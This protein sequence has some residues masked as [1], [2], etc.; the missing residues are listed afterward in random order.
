MLGPII[1]QQA[2]DTYILPGNFQGLSV[3]LGGYVLLVIAGFAAH[4]W[5]LIQLETAGLQIIGT[6]K[7]AAFRHLVNLDLPFFDQHT[8][9]KLVSRIENDANAM[10]I[11][12]SSVMS[13]VVSNLLV[14]IG[15]FGIMAWQYDLK[16]AVYVV[17]ICPLIL[18]AGVLFQRL[19]R[20]LLIRIREKVAEVN[21]LLTEVIQGIGTIQM[22]EQQ[23]RF[24]QRIKESSVAKNRLESWMTIG[25]NS[26]FNVLFFVQNLALALVL[27]FGGNL[28]MD[29]GLSVGSLVLFMV[30]IRTFFG[31]IMFLS[32]Q[33]NE[34]QKAVAGGHRIFDLL[35]Q[36]AQVQNPTA[37]VTAPTGLW[38]IEFKNVYFR[39]PGA[40]G[41]T[42]ENVSFHCKAGE[43]WALVGSTGSGKT[44]IISLL[45]RFYDPQRGQILVN[46]IDIQ[47]LLLKD[48]RA[49]V[50]LVLQDVIFFPGTL[51]QNLVLD[52]Q[53]LE[54]TQV[55]STLSTIG[56]DQLIERL[57]T[58][59]DTRLEEGAHNLSE[60]EQQLLSFGR[61]LLRDPQLLIL[62]EATSH[63]DPETEGKIQSAMHSVLR[64]R[65][66]LIIAHR[67]STIE[68]T[69]QILV[70]DQGK[71]IETGSHRELIARE[72]HYARLHEL[73][74]QHV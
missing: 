54:R 65:T 43:H 40:E 67:L 63:V 25:F 20:P 50:G 53:Q 31:P 73:Q 8:T 45:L 60:G 59:Y 7:K 49:G 6:L 16:L 14:M 2:I 19:M 29:G 5:Q 33:F 10:K 35:Q 17:G 3:L 9:G 11:L 1:L 55:K 21:G 27:W 69:D 41:W 58:G 39:Y 4:Y 23:D 36:R 30:F 64:G 12:F 26:F 13:N 42:L 22:F 37:P 56:L 32:S 61:A 18:A 52:N 28:V 71:V 66:A 44:T 38:D 51:W 34:F 46:G 68:A 47:T 48:L 57:P 15:M 62:D 74:A 24:M 70:L 72:G